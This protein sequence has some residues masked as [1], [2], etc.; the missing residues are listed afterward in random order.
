MF[1]RT[2]SGEYKFTST[3]L[4]ALICCSPKSRQS[5]FSLI[6][7]TYATTSARSDGMMSAKRSSQTVCHLSIPSCLVSETSQDDGH[8]GCHGREH[9]H[10]P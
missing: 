3:D 2:K 1:R 4:P 7:Y 9:L 6:F 8:L 5:Y 10:R